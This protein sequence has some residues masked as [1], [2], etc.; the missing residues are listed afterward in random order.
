MRTSIPVIVAVSGKEKLCPEVIRYAVVPEGLAK[1]ACADAKLSSEAHARCGLANENSLV[2][3]DTL[4]AVEGYV[5]GVA[6]GCAVAAPGLMHVK[7]NTRISGLMQ[8]RCRIWVIWST[9]KGF[10]A[11][12]GC[13]HRLSTGK[14][15]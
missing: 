2:L 15:L 1:L 13:F 5:A 6:P 8:A 9:V 12:A 14:N 10:L 11:I 3:C 4:A 7:D